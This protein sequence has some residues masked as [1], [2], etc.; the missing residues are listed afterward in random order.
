MTL[1]FIISALVF[2]FGI[3]IIYLAYIINKENKDILKLLTIFVKFGLLLYILVSMIITGF[4]IFSLTSELLI[5]AMIIKQIITTIY[6]IFIYQL[7]SKLLYNLKVN[8]IFTLDNSSIIKRI[9]LMF[10]Y[11]SITEIVV[12]LFFAIITFS[13]TRSFNVSTNNTIFVYVII[14]LVL[15]VIS[16]LLKK[17]THIY[18][19]NQLTI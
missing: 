6:Y 17:A 18:E 7:S 15:E 19:E 11:L 1:F 5:T 2:G 12:G 3:F 4:A 9:A 8:H 10:L 16:L 14:A 13:S